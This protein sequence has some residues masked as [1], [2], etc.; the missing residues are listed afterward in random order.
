MA[1]IKTFT[2]TKTKE[3]Q[4]I[5]KSGNDLYDWEKYLSTMSYSGADAVATI[6]LPVIG[7]DGN[8]ESQGDIIT[9]GELQTI[10]YSIH[11][12]NS[13]VRTLGHVNVRGFIKGGRTIA[14][15][16]IFTVFNEYAFYRIKEFKQYLAR[17]TGYFAP[18]ADMLPPFDIVIT[19]FN[20]YG[21]GSKMKI[22]GVT[23]VDEGQTLSIDDLITEQTYTYMA[24]G[25]QPLV[26]MPNDAT[27]SRDA[28]Y[29]D[30]MK[31]RDQ[32]S[33][34]IFGDL[35]IDNLAA[36]NDAEYYNTRYNRPTVAE[37]IISPSGGGGISNAR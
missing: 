24:R 23:I 2:F 8:V 29:P 9:L 15:S 7:P 16:L 20:E 10:S 6:V 32:I 25:I 14:G 18:L 19:F 17:R 5:E 4:P 3:E 13:P 31:E 33:T 22:Y 26:R 21:L 12:E 35:I 11:R 30:E 27:V 36:L 34:N 28:S 37:E 1:E